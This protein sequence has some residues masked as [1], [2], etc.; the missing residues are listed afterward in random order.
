M[1]VY[2]VRHGEDRAAV[3]GRF[4]DEGL[5]E[6]GIAQVRG[7][8]ERL[9]P[10]PFRGCL[11]SPLKRAG[12][13]ARILVEGRS[14]EPELCPDLAEGS[15]GDLEGLT[16]ELARERYP[17]FFRVGRGV[18][19]RL[20]VSASTAPGGESR[21]EFLGRARAAGARISAELETE[22]DPLLV[23]SH[24]GLLNYMLQMLLGLPLRDEVPFGFENAGVA[25]LVRRG[26]ADYGPF[27]SFRVGVDGIDRVAT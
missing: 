12:E 9:A 26:A 8:A 27:L 25:A 1:A 14:I 17:E 2:L 20:A 22:G 3:E 18:V 13:T 7:L 4:G 11:V 5:S 15:V 6:R 19:E 21:D 23:V 24:G 10:I 16:K